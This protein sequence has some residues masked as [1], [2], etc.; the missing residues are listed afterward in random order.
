M[1]CRWMVPLALALCF[2]TAGA[3]RAAEAHAEVTRTDEALAVLFS[4]GAALEFALAGDT[5]LGLRTA[6]ASG[7]ALTSGETLLRPVIADDAWE[8]K[9]PWLVH[10]MTLRDVRAADDG[11]VTLTLELR[12]TTAEAAL[13]A[14]YLWA[15]DEAR[16][17]GEAATP[18][19][20][21]AQGKARAA[22]ERLNAAADALPEVAAQRD[23]IAAYEK[24]IADPTDA[25]RRR[26]GWL[27]NQLAKEEAKLPPL[28]EA[29]YPKLAKT[30]PALAEAWRDVQAF[31]ALLARR[32]LE[33]GGIHRDY[34]GSAMFRLPS[35][36]NTPEAVRAL[37][38]AGGPGAAGAGT[39]RWVLAPVDVNVAGWPYQGWRHHYEVDLAGGRTTRFVRETGTWELG[40]QAVGSTLVAVRYRGLGGFDETF[41]GG[42][43]GGIDRN[44]TTTETIPG[45]AGGAP[46]ISPVV[47]PGEDRRDRGFGLRHRVSPWIGRMIRGV[48]SPMVDVQHRPEGVFASFPDHLGDLRAVTEAFTGDRAVSQTNEEAFARTGSLATTP[49]LYVALAAP[50]GA[51]FALHECRTRWQELDAYT[52]RRVSEELGFVQAEPL[53]GV[54]LNIDTAWERRIADLAGRMDAYADLGM[55]MILVHQPGWMNGRGLKECKDPEYSKLAKGGGDCSIYD[56]VPRP[57]VAKEWKALTRKLAEH[58]VAYLVW[59]SFF[60]VGPGG[61][62]QE[63]RDTRGLREA[64]FSAYENPNVEPGGPVFFESL[65]CAHNPNTKALLDLFVS[66]FD[67]ARERYG[68]NGIWA[69]SWHKWALVVGNGPRRKPSFRAWMEQ[70]AR[71]SREGLAF[72]SEGQGA[73]IMSCSLELSEQR[74]EDEW[75]FLPQTTLWYRGKSLPPGAGT[76]EADRHTFRLMA[77]RCWPFVETGWGQDV[78]KVIPD[79]GRLAHEYNAALPLMRRSHVLPG[80][81]GVLWLGYGGDGKGAWFPFKAGPVP[82]GVTATGITDGRPAP[83]AEAYRTY[84]VE[85]DD[86]VAAFGL[87]RGSEKDPRLGRTYRPMAYRWPAWATENK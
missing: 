85:A 73:P 3:V 38:E 69:D 72:V 83:R 35:E 31:E 24:R 49:M 29:A 76:V 67:T 20:R 53:P 59:C 41:G 62:V 57:T 37:A 47:P 11:T 27:R 42:A 74:F 19:L 36:A 17:L 9:E 14:V 51:P 65:H 8:Q 22:R 58:E 70:F 25:D 12:A 5:L 66:R 77:N 52:R 56:Y 13:K 7:L 87:R 15:G 30:D 16:A 80:G 1:R 81:A 6:V 33:V 61:F 84:A 50:G 40:G 86:L 10:E 60:S 54:G 48:G 23:A 79:F 4:N 39:L 45:A 43:G 68:H 82:K 71:W 34:F 32:A 64:D 21:E 28:R 2:A 78:L 26:L 46:L 63:L 18:E 44:F 55:R 75:W